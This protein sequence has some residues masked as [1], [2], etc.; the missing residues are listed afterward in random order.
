MV[1]GGDSAVTE[2]LHLHNLG[3]DIIMIHRRDRLRAQEQ[4]VKSLS[5]SGIPIFYNTEIKEIREKIMWQ[6]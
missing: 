1:G 4:L 2:A 5:L 3:V 6:K